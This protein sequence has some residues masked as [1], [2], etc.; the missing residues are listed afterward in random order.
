MLILN[1]QKSEVIMIDQDPLEVL[2]VGSE[3]VRYRFKNKTRK[4]FSGKAVRLADGIGMTFCG[5]HPVLPSS[6]RLGF[7]APKEIDIHRLEV[8][9]RIQ[10]EKAA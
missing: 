2:S 7:T 3:F 4:L 6:A 10:K 8:F 1:R 5:V 9:N